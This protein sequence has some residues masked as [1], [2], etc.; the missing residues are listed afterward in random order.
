VEQTH[1][2]FVPVSHNG[3]HVDTR[4]VTFVKQ[5]GDNGKKESSIHIHGDGLFYFDAHHNTVEDYNNALH[6][7]ELIRRDEVYISIDGSHTGIGGDQAW[8]TII[9]EKHLAKAGV[10]RTRFNVKFD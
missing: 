1:F 10:H 2:P 9:D 7:H 6:E 5:N 3:G 4:H 8:S